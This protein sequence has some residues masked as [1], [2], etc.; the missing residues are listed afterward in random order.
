MNNENT[1]LFAYGSLQLPE[2][3]LAVTGLSLR[4]EPARL[5]GF[6]RYCIVGKSYPGIRPQPGAVV[7]GLLFGAIDAGTWARL[8]CFEDDFYQ[9]EAVTVTTPD[10]H[11]H[12]AQAYL[13]A[14]ESYGLLTG[15]AW[16]LEG[17]EQRD[18]ASFLLKH[19]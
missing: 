18:L 2:V 4:G 12:A 6:A 11:A 13:V 17:F 15:Q 8:D 3:M 9:R 10:G 19:E 5:P 16:S 7:E 14:P 1:C